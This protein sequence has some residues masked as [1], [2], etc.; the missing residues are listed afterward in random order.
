MEYEMASIK[1]TTL[2]SES[3]AL[4]VTLMQAWITDPGWNGSVC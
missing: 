2:K 1:A 3:R 4:F